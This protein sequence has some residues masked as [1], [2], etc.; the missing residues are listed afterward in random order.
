MGNRQR[1][2]YHSERRSRSAGSVGAGPTSRGS[3]P[4]TPSKPT[5]RELAAR[6]RQRKW[7]AIVAEYRRLVAQEEEES[8]SA[9]L[10]TPASSSAPP[11]SA[12]A[13]QRNKPP[14]VRRRG[15]AAIRH[16]QAA[17]TTAA[18]HRACRRK[19]YRLSLRM[20]HLE[21]QNKNLEDRLKDL[22][23]QLSDHLATGHHRK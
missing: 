3:T 17:P 13:S 6:A 8:A 5:R 11:G 12:A 4:N 22:R 18:P 7:E 2:P 1:L 20:A 16:R 21:R 23:R 14:G 15:L 10:P 19:F 9:T